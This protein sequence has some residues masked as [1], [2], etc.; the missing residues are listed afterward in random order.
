[1]AGVLK[2]A[3]SVPSFEPMSTTRSS[4]PGQAWRRS[5][6]AGRRNCRAESGRS[7]GVGYSGGKIIAGS[8][9]RPSCTSWQLRQC[10]SLVGNHGCWRGPCRSA[11]SGSP[12]A[13]SR[14]TARHRAA[15]GR[16]PD[17]IDRDAGA[18]AGGAR[19]FGRSIIYFLLRRQVRVRQ[20][21]SS[22]GLRP[23]VSGTRGL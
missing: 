7:A 13:C 11:A 23:S 2:F 6:G 8:T 3:S 20:Y 22:V 21:Q 9:T 5:R 15:H 14:A 18:G 10:R 17:S 4:R 19:N 16:R 12:A 1:M